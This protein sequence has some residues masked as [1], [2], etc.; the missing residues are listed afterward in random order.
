MG[1]LADRLDPA[2]APVE[3][4][5]DLRAVAEAVDAVHRSE[6][7]LTEAVHLARARGHSWNR[8][9]VALGV[10]RQAARQRYGNK[11]A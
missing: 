8:I 5:S 11:A 2:T 7:G 4:I 1:V 3:D 6:A 9:A 10:S